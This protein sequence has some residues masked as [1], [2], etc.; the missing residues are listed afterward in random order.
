[1]RRCRGTRGAGM[2]TGL[3][4]MFAFTAGGVIWLAR[5]VDRSISHRSSAQSIAFQAARSGA[6]EIDLFAVRLGEVAAVP[7]DVGAA[8]R[9]AAQTA[10]EL[11]AAYQLD[12][13]VRSIVVEGDRVA[14]EVAVRD[15]GRVVTGAGA[16]R[17]QSGP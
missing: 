3:V 7:L 4:L 16:A 11:F 14:V 9:A 15:A 6:Q 1:M 10:A 2:V 17:S 8:Q 12:G 5:D 13:V